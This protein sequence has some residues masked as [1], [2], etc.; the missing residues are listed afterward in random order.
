[1]PNSYPRDRILNPKLTTILIFLHI[2][3]EFPRDWPMQ[4]N[5]VLHGG[6]R[7]LSSHAWHQNVLRIFN[8]CEVPIE[9]SVT[10]VAVRHHEACRVMR[11]NSYPEWRN[12]QFALNNHYIRNVFFFLHTFSSTIA[13]KFR[14]VLFYQFT[15]FDHEC[16]GWLLSTT[17]TSKRLAETDVKMTSWRHARESSYNPAPVLDNISLHRSR[18][19]P[20][21]IQESYNVCLGNIRHMLVPSWFLAGYQHWKLKCFSFSSK[22]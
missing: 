18:K 6:G 19:F 9:N 7:R 4:E 21:G 14:F 12:F 3:Q 1:M 22:L 2:R 10:R 8:G 11:Q 13:F 17:L 16:S 15:L 20:L 5:V